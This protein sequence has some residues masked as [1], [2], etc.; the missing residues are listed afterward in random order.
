VEL[1]TYYGTDLDTPTE[2][3]FWPGGFHG[4][5]ALSI[6]G[7]PWMSRRAHLRVEVEQ[8][9]GTTLAEFLQIM[10]VQLPQ[11]LDGML[12]S[13]VTWNWSQGDDGFRVGIDRIGI[14]AL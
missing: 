7:D 9:P 5:D 1:H 2:P 6:G 8:Q 3:T 11:L 10:N 4:P 12:P 14:D 13:W